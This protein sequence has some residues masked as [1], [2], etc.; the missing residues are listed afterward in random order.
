M[1]RIEFNSIVGGLFLVLCDADGLEV[2]QAVN[3]LFWRASDVANRKEMLKGEK[4]VY[5][6]WY[7]SSNKRRQT[8]DRGII[9]TGTDGGGALD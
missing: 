4:R 9:H 6:I 8:T 5:M 2:L 7:C 1:D 3:E